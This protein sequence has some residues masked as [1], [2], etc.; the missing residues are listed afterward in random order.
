MRCF[1][2]HAAIPPVR[3]WAQCMLIESSNITPVGFRY[4]RAAKRVF[5]IRSPAMLGIFKPSA[6]DQSPS[7]FDRLKTGLKKT[8]LRIGDLLVGR[9]IDESLFEELESALLAADT[10]V[11]A[12][13]DLMQK[14]RGRAR[15]AR[16]ETA[17]QLRAELHAVFVEAL[18]PLQTTVEIGSQRPFVIMLA[19]VNGAGKTTSIGKIACMLRAR[20]LSVMLAAG[21]TF[22]AA[23][24]EQLEVWGKRNDV[25]VVSQQGADAA[26]VIFDAV[27]SARARGIDVVLADTAGRLHTQT[28]LME[29][30][31]KIKRVIAKAD[32]RA[33]HAVWLVLDANTGQNALAQFKAFDDALGLTGLILTK[34]DGTAKGGVIA[35]IAQTQRESAARSPGKGVVPVAYIGVGEGIDDLRPFVADEFVSALLAEE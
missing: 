24:R 18:S 25:V 11:A 2:L 21:D 27:Q 15:A 8:G 29:E 4:S 20:G 19:G 7:W 5:A 28:H 17:E 3:F 1:I 31:K 9:K 33:P 6:K 14:L 26:S 10:G 16:L 30:L 22:R 13:G 32:A 12:T 23:A 35:A 34:L